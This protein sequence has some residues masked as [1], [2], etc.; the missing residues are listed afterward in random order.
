MR[1]ATSSLCAVLVLSAVL[2]DFTVAQ[3]QLTLVS[4][5]GANNSGDYGVPGSDK[6][7][8]QGFQTP[9][10]TSYV[11]D[12]VGLKLAGAPTDS[13]TFDVTLWS[14]SGGVPGTQLLTISSGVPI[15]L[16]PA[17]LTDETFTAAGGFPLSP[18]TSYFIVVKGSE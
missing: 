18:S 12:S 1:C 13:G 14:T 6:W 17:S 3:A 16:L 9:S 15:S 5:L 10:G 8:A 11:L 2:S 7:I 4:N